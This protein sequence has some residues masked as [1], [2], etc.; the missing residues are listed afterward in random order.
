MT[1]TPRSDVSLPGRLSRR[2]LVRLA[3]ALA[4][5]GGAPAVAACRGPGAGGSDGGATGGGASAGG[6]ATLAASPVA[7]VK[8]PASAGAPAAQAITGFSER[9]IA[10]V[11]ATETGNVIASPFSV[12]AALAMTVNGA[13]GRTAQEMLTVLG[14]LSAADL[15]GGVA[16]LSD[17]FA[18][19][20]GAKTRGD[21]TTAQLAVDIANSLWAQRDTAWAQVFLD[22]LARWF[23][24]GVNLVDYRTAPEP[25]RERINAWT[26]TATHDKIQDLVPPGAVGRDTRLVLVNAVYL[27]A[28]WEAPFDTSATAPGP[29]RL[30]SV[31]TVQTDF[32]RNS[33]E[34]GYAAKGPGF[35]AVTLPYV[36]RE[37]GMTLVLTDGSDAAA[38]SAWLRGGG[39]SSALAALQPIG[40]VN[41][42]LPK[43]TFRT[44]LELSK[45]LA[46]LGMPTAFG[47][48]ADFS[49][50]TA[51]EALS[52]SKVLHQG[53]V[54]VDEHGT[55]AAAATA[56]V[57]REVAAPAEPLTVVLD[58]PFLFVVHDLQTRAPLFL[59]R[60]A[61]P[62]R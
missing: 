25:A 49:G 41:L 36:G 32:M 39:L 11:L 4:V 44:T 5:I 42:T 52:I 16:L 59:G 8:P 10:T 33:V 58:R 51:A 46:G 17:T 43:W 13:K 40:A 23:G 55:E 45:V 29:F 31:A 24:A 12:A 18:G 20:A 35:L 7:R 14:G 30:A 61:D 6:G 48:E 27:K 54:S 60:V 15:S 22:D 53:Y 62:S 19:R 3:A 50:M 26:A 1:A 28:P 56:V 37:L 34:G 21:G 9:M 47:G 57:M 38:H 2:D